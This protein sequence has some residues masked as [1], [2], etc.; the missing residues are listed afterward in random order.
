MR[1]IGL[2]GS[3]LVSDMLIDAGVPRYAK[4]AA[5]VLLSGGEPV[6]L[7]GL[8]LAEGF[9]PDGRTEKVLRLDFRAEPDHLL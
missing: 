3:K 6:W 1:P 7:A 4:A 8:R 2:H 5:F 9:S